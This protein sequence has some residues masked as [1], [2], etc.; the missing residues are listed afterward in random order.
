M[1]CANPLI[2]IE[3]WNPAQQAVRLEAMAAIT[4][5]VVVGMVGQVSTGYQAAK[6]VVSPAEVTIYGP[7]VF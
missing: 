4:L 3:S 2:R 1:T 7:E 6:P 5:P